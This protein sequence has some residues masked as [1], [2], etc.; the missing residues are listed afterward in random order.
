MLFSYVVEMGFRR[1]ACFVLQHKLHN[2][3]TYKEDYKGCQ[4]YQ[5]QLLPVFSTSFSYKIQQLQNYWP[6]IHAPIMKLKR[7]KKL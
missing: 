6:I 3:L 7:K 1:L 4:I 2:L 5:V